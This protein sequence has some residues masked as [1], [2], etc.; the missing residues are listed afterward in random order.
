MDRTAGKLIKAHGRL[1]RALPLWG[2]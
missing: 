2:K 1:P